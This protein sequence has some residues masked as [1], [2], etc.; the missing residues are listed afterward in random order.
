MICVDLVKCFLMDVPSGCQVEK[1]RFIF[2]SSA[3]LASSCTLKTKSS[4][5]L[6]QG[7]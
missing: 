3:T 5:L 4:N 6:L 2:H 1:C 7:L